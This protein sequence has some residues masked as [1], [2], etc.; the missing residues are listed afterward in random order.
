ME[1]VRLRARWGARKES[2]EECA[3][4]LLLF[5]QHLA[6]C[7]DAFA[8]KWLEIAHKPG[9]E[10]QTR[11]DAMAA[12]F[13]PVELSHESLRELFNRGRFRRE[14]W[15]SVIEE[16]GFTSGSFWN[17]CEAASAHVSVN[18]GAYP[19]SRTMPG[20][21]RA[22]IDFPNEGPAAERILQPEKLRQIMTVVVENWDPDWA[23]VSTNKTDSEIYQENP[24][25]G[26]MV[27]W[28]T[29]VSDRYG[30]LPALPSNCHLSRI[31]NRGSVIVID[32]QGKLTAANS[33]HVA[34]LEVLSHALN[35]AG[36][37][38]PIP[39]LDQPQQ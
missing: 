36:L 34:S 22:W 28:L 33:V 3:S 4:R 25:L 38:S 18:C 21:N 31:G 19:D 26:Q 15:N 23:R 29:Y 5:L 8:Q 24:Y 13:L 10:S 7:D 35:E 16:L 17:G 20:S 30:Q 9:A 37:L 27:G 12:R 6:C 2:V 11:E 14:R 39:P 1:K 32:L